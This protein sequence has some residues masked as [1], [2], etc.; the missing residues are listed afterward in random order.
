MVINYPPLFVF[1]TGASGSGKTFFANALEKNL[2]SRYAHVAYFDQIGVPSVE[3]MIHDYGSCEGWQEAM[4]YT[5]FEKLAQMK[6]KKIIIFEG[7]Y[8]PQFIVNACKKYGITNYLLI[9]IHAKKVVREQRLL[10]QRQQPELINDTMNNWAEFL[11]EKT[12]MLGGAIIDTSDS[13]VMLQLTVIESL[14]QKHIG[15]EI[16]GQKQ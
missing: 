5:W 14:I 4:T 15:L 13:D 3:T 6:D 10:K 12:Q 2:D 9:V 7:Q 1:L 11:K 16:S 8:N